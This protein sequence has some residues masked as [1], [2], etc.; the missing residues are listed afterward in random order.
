MHANTLTSVQKPHFPFGSMGRVL[1]RWRENSE[2]RSAIRTLEDMPDYILRDM[3]L[4]RDG[5]RHAVRH[6]TTRQTV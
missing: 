3:G 1:R 5:I 4:T 6:S 2:R